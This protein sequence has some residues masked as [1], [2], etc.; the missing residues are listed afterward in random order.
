MRSKFAWLV[1]GVVISLAFPA[2]AGGYE[3]TKSTQECLNA[4][5]EKLQKRGWVGIE[6]DKD[7]DAGT[8]TVK[9]V[10]SDSPAQAAGFKIGD[11]LVAVNGIRYN[12]ESKKEAL[13]KAYDAMTPGA[14]VTYTV[15]RSG[16]EKDLDV[17]LGKLPEEVLAQWIG[18][19]M[20]EHAVIA[21]AQSGN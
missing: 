14:Q 2:F 20:I 17:K 8:M 4:M 11:Q 5:A 15:S 9:R 13:Q 6:L 19:H 7:E 16:Y 1:F 18:G 3:C 21:Q 12:D 10:V